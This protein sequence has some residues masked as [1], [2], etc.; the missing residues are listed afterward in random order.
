MSCYK[1]VVHYHFK[2]GKEKEG[3]KFIENELLHAAEECGCHNIEFCQDEKDSCHFV[4]M[5]TW[6]DMKSWKKFHEHWKANEHKLQELCEHHPHRDMYIV[7]SCHM[8]K[9]NKA[10]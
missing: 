8:K 7:Q 6:D 5:G 4:G 9:K 3:K 2:K 1:A 10:A